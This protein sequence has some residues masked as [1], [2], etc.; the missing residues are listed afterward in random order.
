MIIRL[1][2]YLNK[3]NGYDPIAFIN[4]SE[5]QIPAAGDIVK[6]DHTE[7]QVIG[8]LYTEHKPFEASPMKIVTGL[9]VKEYG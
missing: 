6:L 7:V 1:S 4:F 5:D 9:I 3:L 8:R 2:L